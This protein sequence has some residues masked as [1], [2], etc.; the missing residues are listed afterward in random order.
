MFIVLFD[1]VNKDV[2]S[3]KEVYIDL[4]GDKYCIGCLNDCSC[5]WMVE[6]FDSDSLL[7][8]L[9]DVI[10]CCVVEVYGSLEKY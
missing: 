8:V 4:M 7:N 1:L 9:V 3:L 5:M 10:N 2:V 6:V